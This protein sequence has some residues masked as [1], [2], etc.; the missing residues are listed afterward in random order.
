VAKNLPA[1]PNLD[2]L[3]RQAKTLLARLNNGDAEAVRTFIDHLPAARKMSAANVCGAG[4]RLA[5]A[6]SAIARAT[7]FASWPAL[8]H[9]VQ[10]L[11]TLE[12]EWQFVDLTIDG[13]AMPDAAFSTS[14]LLID[15]DRFRT[16][17]PGGVYEGVFTI[18]VEATPRQIDIEF[19]EGPEAGNWSYGVYELKGDQLTICLGLVGAPRPSGFTTSVGS[20]HALE[21][22]RRTSA[23]RP[24]DVKGG[25]RQP[26][27]AKRPTPQSA[28]VDAF[29]FD[30]Q[31]TSLLTRL[32]GDWLAVELNQ[33]GQAMPAEW[34]TFGSR[35][36][37][38]NETKVVFSGQVMLH[39]K[40]RVD[41]TAS[42]LNIDYLHLSA[43]NR[44]LVSLGIMEWIADDV[45]FAIAAPGQ[46]RP[47]DFE[48]GSRRTISRWRRKTTG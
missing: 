17:S 28:P 20:G 31:T 1:R 40:I 42:P 37:T 46:P 38:G 6:Q 14:L 8:A 32:Q 27:T 44:G 25:T 35:T 34:L 41:E 9:H 12:G 10:E 7:G 11:R 5:D 15:G 2:H 30:V 39:A 36:T 23:A 45:R 22:L 19:V 13:N 26:K 3:R 48:P 4:F 18:D 47:I 33:D 21:R 29:A 24:A 16:E 43:A